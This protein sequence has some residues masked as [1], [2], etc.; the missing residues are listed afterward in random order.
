MKRESCVIRDGELWES[1]RLGSRREIGCISCITV[2]L[3]DVD[4]SLLI[5]ENVPDF[6]ERFLVSGSYI[7]AAL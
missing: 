2:A 6:F 7:V 1:H 5:M 3:Y 4:V